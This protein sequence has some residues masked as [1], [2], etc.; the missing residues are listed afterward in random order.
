MPWDWPVEVNNLEAQA[1][2]KWK[3]LKTQSKIRLPTED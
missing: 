2:C 1:F 3:S